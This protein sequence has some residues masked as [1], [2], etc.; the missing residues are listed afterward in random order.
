MK[1]VINALKYFRAI[2]LVQFQYLIILIHWQLLY[3]K[4]MCMKYIC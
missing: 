4:N 2:N 3:M 1:F